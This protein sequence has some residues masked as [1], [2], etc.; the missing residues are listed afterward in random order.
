MFRRSALAVLV[1]GSA[2]APD[3]RA[4]V[5]LHAHTDLM[6][7]HDYRWR[8]I[9]RATGWNLQPE[10]LAGFRGD[11]TAL[12]AGIWANLELGTHRDGA[13]TDLAPGDWGLSEA[14]VWAELSRSFGWGDL[15]VGAI[16]YEYR[17]RAGRID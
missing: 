3:S 16:R 9:I 10:V 13:L 14:N 17:G 5:R 8:G 7:V 4:Q 15:A 12:A 1:V 6:A 11:R 2:L